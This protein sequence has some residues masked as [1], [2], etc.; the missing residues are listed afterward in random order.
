S[1]GDR[2]YNNTAEAMESASNCIQCGECESKCPY[3]LPIV[4]AIAENVE[5]YEQ[6]EP[7]ILR[8]SE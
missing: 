6:Q 5:W 2:Y 7:Y 4:D 3:G 8:T 1:Y